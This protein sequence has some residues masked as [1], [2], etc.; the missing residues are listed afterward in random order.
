MGKYYDSM[1]IEYINKT[2]EHSHPTSA[3][4]IMAKKKNCRIVIST[5]PD[6]EIKLKMNKI[7]QWPGRDDI[8]CRHLFGNSFNFKPKFRFFTN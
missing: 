7:K 1:E 6:L 2:K 4:P 8:Q 5:E 3:D